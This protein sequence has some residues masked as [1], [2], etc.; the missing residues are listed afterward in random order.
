MDMYPEPL[1]GRQWR[2]SS[3]EVENS[4]AM[5]ARLVQTAR[6]GTL[7]A[8]MCRSLSSPRWDDAVVLISDNLWSWPNRT[9]QD[10]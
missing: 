6:N 3:A 1:A 9:C 2:V 10:L 4:N 5:A 8:R 7:R